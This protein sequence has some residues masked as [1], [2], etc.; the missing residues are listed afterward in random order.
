MKVKFIPFLFIVAFL[1]CNKEDDC[2]TIT[3]KRIV[4]N[5][6][7]FYFDAQELNNLPQNSNPNQGSGYP[8]RYASGQVDKETYDSTNVGDKYCN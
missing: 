5:K 1:S 6:Y 4:D 2:Y 7:Y 3:E 8:D